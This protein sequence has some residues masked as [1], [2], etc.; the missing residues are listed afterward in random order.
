MIAD[1]I[2]FDFERIVGC[3]HK[4]GNISGPTP[5]KATNIPLGL[6]YQAVE[7]A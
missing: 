1:Q 3:R 2:H 7:A 4:S 6:K 5:R